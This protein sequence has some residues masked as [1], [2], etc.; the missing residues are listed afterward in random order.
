MPRSAA[1]SRPALMRNRPSVVTSSSRA[2]GAPAETLHVSNA[3][4]TFCWA[5]V[6]VPPPAH[7]AAAVT[8][9]SP[10]PMSVAARRILDVDGLAEGAEGRLERGLGQRRVRVDRVDELLEGGL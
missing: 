9:A 8:I 10:A 2:V 3:S 6:I 7:P 4:W 5:G 1:T